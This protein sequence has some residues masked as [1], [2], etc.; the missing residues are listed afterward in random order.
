MRICFTVRGVDELR[1]LILIHQNFISSENPESVYVL[2]GKSGMGTG[3]ITHSVLV[4]NSHPEPREG[5]Q[6]RRKDLDEASAHL[7]DAEPAMVPL[8]VVHTHEGPEDA[9]PSRVD[10]ESASPDHLNL[11]LSPRHATY[12]VF[13][14]DGTVETYQLHRDDLVNRQGESLSTKMFHTTTPE[15]HDT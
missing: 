15:G 14:R 4:H 13:D 1:T 11:V 6:V 9:W 10:F 2:Y 8:G 3:Y 5:F 12:A 7:I